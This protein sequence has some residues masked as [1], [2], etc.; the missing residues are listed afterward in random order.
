MVTQFANT[1][2]VS[3]TIFVLN[4]LLN[5]VYVISYNVGWWV[6]WL[7][8]WYQRNT[9]NKLN[10]VKMNCYIMFYILSHAWKSLV[11]AWMGDC[12]GRP[13]SVKLCPFVGVDLNL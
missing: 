12:Q 4:F 10:I 8:G 3:K 1:L 9:K 6:G 13:S 2:H 11:S 5:A 7:V